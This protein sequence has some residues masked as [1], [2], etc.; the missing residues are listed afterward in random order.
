MEQEIPQPLKSAQSILAELP[1]E[2][3]DTLCDRSIKKRGRVVDA[4]LSKLQMQAEASRWDTLQS[5]PLAMLRDGR[6]MEAAN[7][8]GLTIAR[9]WYFDI[10]VIL[11]VIGNVARSML[12]SIIEWDSEATHVLRETLY[13]LWERI[14]VLAEYNTN[15]VIYIS[16]GWVFEW[17]WKNDLALQAYTEAIKLW[18]TDA[19]ICIANMYEKSWRYTESADILKQAHSITKDDRFLQWHISALSKSGERSEAYK[20]YI[21]LVKKNTKPTLQSHATNTAPIMQ[22]TSGLP[23]FIVF[24]EEVHSDTDLEEFSALL[25]EYYNEWTFLPNPQLRNLAENAS[26][27]ISNE[28]EWINKVLRELIMTPR[29]WWTDEQIWLHRGL[30]KRRLYLMQTHIILLQ[31]HRYLDGYLHDMHEIAM[32]GNSEDHKILW[33]FFTEYF[34]PYTQVAYDHVSENQ[35]EDTEKMDIFESLRLHLIHIMAIFWQW[36]L[37]E[38]IRDT[39]EPLIDE[40]LRRAWNEV[41]IEESSGVFHFSEDDREGYTVTTQA[42]SREDPNMMELRKENK[43]YNALSASTMDMYEKYAWYLDAKYGI[44]Y[45]RSIQQLVRDRA[46][47]PPSVIWGLEASLIKYG[48]DKERAF[49]EIIHNMPI[50]LEDPYIALFFFLEKILLWHDILEEW[51]DIDN[52]IIKYWFHTLG[53]DEAL[54][55]ASMLYDN[56]YLDYAIQYA[57]H[58]PW[59]LQEP[60]AL[61]MIM[62]HLRYIDNDS[63]DGD[64]ADEDATEDA[65]E[66]QNDMREFSQDPTEATEWDQETQSQKLIDTLNS[67]CER[68]YNISD[69]F[70]YFD[71]FMQNVIEDEQATDMDIWYTL[72]ASGNMRCIYGQGEDK[73]I[74]E[75]VAAWEYGIVHG[76]VSAAD[77]L[78]DMGDHSS[79]LEYLLAAHRLSPSI[80][81]IRRLA[82]IYMETGDFWE[83]WKLLDDSTRDGYDVVWYIS[84]CY[85]YE[86]KTRE[87][88]R[89][90]SRIISAQGDIDTV[91]PDWYEEE[92]GRRIKIE[93]NTPIASIEDFEIS[94]LGSYI[95]ADRMSTDLHDYLNHV[96]DILKLL[97]TY[98]L[99]DACAILAKTIPLL[100]GA[101]VI[102]SDMS[103]IESSLIYTQLHLERMHGI[104][105]GAYKSELLKNGNITSKDALKILQLLNSFMMSAIFIVKYFPDSE[106]YVTIWQRA[107]NFYATDEYQPAPSQYIHVMPSTIQ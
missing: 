45:R 7:F 105:L 97:D 3:Y 41:D 49:M 64:N 85:L 51:Q 32:N 58:I 50:L 78:E 29:E 82:S 11:E 56:G 48:G 5:I 2:K 84:A 54:L 61:Y 101:I 16:I 87:A 75:F 17:E 98:K 19:Y 71:W 63:P 8:V 38:D 30:V 68:D 67:I 1:P 10:N 92:I 100:T 35:W 26:I 42:D 40:C 23:P 20:H 90:F 43:N 39:L 88:L 106:K 31:D 69:F 104:I 73:I 76:Y 81:T 95:F 57:I 44:F 96:R 28:I 55:L 24:T 15:P 103:S 94:I 77:I 99:E 14:L 52:W 46:A 72:L 36:T 9:G 18:S 6:Y 47:I 4:I 89:E 21:E 74:S 86:W 22:P 102:P 80:I 33:E 65:V 83:V 34:N 59:M 12:I 25:I 93:I 70:E 62:E 13:W 53:T 79:A 37:Y 27:Y 91:F 66:M 107:I 60:Q